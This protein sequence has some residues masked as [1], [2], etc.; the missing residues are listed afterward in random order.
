LSVSVFDTISSYF[1]RT[2]YGFKE[3]NQIFISIIRVY[4]GAATMIIKLPPVCGSQSK[5]IIYS[6]VDK[7]IESKDYPVELDCSDIVF[8]TSYFYR[9]LI[10]V[11][12]RISSRGGLLTLINVPD[13]VKT[14]LISCNFD[15]IVPIKGGY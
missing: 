10:N 7:A 6:K 2:I 9:F 8:T 13:S 12:K 4:V 1:Y 11:Y 3:L 14:A 15:K 5:P